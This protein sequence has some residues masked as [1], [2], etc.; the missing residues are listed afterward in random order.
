MKLESRGVIRALINM[1]NYFDKEHSK[2]LSD[3]KSTVQ[4][5]SYSKSS[6]YNSYEKNRI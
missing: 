1:F 3:D 5:S 6:S 4:K 2:I